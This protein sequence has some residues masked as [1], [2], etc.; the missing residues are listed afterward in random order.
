MKGKSSLDWYHISWFLCSIQ[1]IVNFLF[2]KIWLPFFIAWLI[3]FVLFWTSELIE[4]RQKDC[5]A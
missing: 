1:V 2:P 5:V 4:R 3:S